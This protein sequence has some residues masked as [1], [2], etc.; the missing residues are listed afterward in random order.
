MIVVIERPTP[1][2]MLCDATVDFGDGT[3]PGSMH[4]GVGD[5]HQ[6]TLQHKYAAIGDVRG[7]GLMVGVEFVKDRETREPAPEVPHELVGR[8][9]QKGLLLLGAGKSSLRLA[10]PLVVDDYDVDTALRIIDSC[11]GEM[12]D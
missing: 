12:S 2:D 9:F 7:R 11:L 8:A 5:K 4:F 10:P 1:L 3:P 6:K